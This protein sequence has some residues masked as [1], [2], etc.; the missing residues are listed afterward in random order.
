MMDICVFACIHVCKQ[1]C[2]IGRPTDVYQVDWLNGDFNVSGLNEWMHVEG[3]KG[4]QLYNWLSY[5]QKK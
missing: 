1:E 3:L 2:I 4:K 5:R